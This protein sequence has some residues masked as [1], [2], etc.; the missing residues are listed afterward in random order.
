MRVLVTG[1]CGFIGS[2]LVDELVKSHEVV[3][4]DRNKDGFKNEKATYVHGDLCNQEDIQKCMPVDVVFH[5]SANVDIRTGVKN[6]KPDFEDNILSTYNLLEVMRENKVKTIVFT[7]SNVVNGEAEQIPTPETYGPLKPISL[8]GGTKLACDALI[9]SYCGTFGF[10][11]TV[12]RFANIVGSRSTH[13]VILDFIRKLKENPNE[14]EILGDGKQTK[15]YLHVS[16]CVSG[17]LAAFEKQTENFDIFNL[18]TEQQTNV[19]RIAEIVSEE[20]DLKPEFRYTGGSRGWVG[21]V[22]IFLLDIKKIQSLGWNYKYSS[23]ESIRK[24]VRELLL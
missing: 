1:G 3:V 2:H 6:T 24:S 12:L 7:S 21:D 10:K 5:L 16:D 13:G 17:I 4:L 15:S 11:G 23:D 8:Y 14:L 9:S 20:L 19:T 18:G 22:P